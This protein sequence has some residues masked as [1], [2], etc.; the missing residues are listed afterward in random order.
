MLTHILNIIR[1][2]FLILTISCLFL[3]VSNASSYNYLW[4]VIM[5]SLCAHISVNSFNEYF[6]YKSGLDFLTLKTKFSGGSGVLPHHPHL[7]PLVLYIAIISLSIVIVIGI[8]LLTVSDSRLFIIGM[9]GILLIVFYTSV[10]N[11]Y[12]LLSLIS[13]GLGFGLLVLESGLVLTNTIDISLVIISVIVF[14]LVNNLLLLNQIPDVVAD[15]QVGRSNII[16]KYGILASRRV[17]LGFIIIPIL[18]LVYAITTQFISPWTSIALLPMS[19]GIYIWRSTI[20]EKI[21]ALNV[22]II[23]AIPVLL[24]VGLLIGE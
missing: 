2:P 9:I 16:I 1:A 10:I 23:N 5:G 14:F 15:A 11:K 13:A 18:L 7:L 8:F 21:L 6:D 4:L 22:V 12:A 17:Y 24:G 20:S 19:L 3:V